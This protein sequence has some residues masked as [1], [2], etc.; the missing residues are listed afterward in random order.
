[1]HLHVKIYHW[2]KF[3]HHW[4]LL[5]NIDKMDRLLSTHTINILNLTFSMYVYQKLSLNTKIMLYFS[6]SNCLNSTFQ[7]TTW[8]RN[9]KIRV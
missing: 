3:W 9:N 4:E 8:N 7:M 2:G 5:V 1:M 6:N